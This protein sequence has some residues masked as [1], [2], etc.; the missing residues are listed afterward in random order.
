MRPGGGVRA[1]GLGVEALG[2]DV[3]RAG[4]RV[5]SQLEIGRGLGEALRRRI[6]GRGG[7]WFG[8]RRKGRGCVSMEGI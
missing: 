7:A 4:L 3:E 2:L 5:Q 6:P 1:L 8:L